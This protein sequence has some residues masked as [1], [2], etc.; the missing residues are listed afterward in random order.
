MGK[1]VFWV[2]YTGTCTLY[3]DF[4]VRYLE[5]LVNFLENVEFLI[6][7]QNQNSWVFQ[8]FRWWNCFFE[9]H[10][11]LELINQNFHII[12][13]RRKRNFKKA[14]SASEPL[15]CARILILGSKWK[16]N[17][18]QKICKKFLCTVHRNLCTMQRFL[19]TVHRKLI[20]PYWKSRKEVFITCRHWKQKLLENFKT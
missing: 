11:L 7:T 13:S 17:I 3:T 12:I 2:R 19:C 16:F 1:W 15:K 8:G 9:F 5:M 10:F 6:K 4:C 18:L 20:C 14:I